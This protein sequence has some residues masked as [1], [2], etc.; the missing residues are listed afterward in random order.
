MGDGLRVSVGGAGGRNR[1]AEWGSVCG[2]EGVGEVRSGFEK[3][4]SLE[5]VCD[6]SMVFLGCEVISLYCCF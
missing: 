3:E 6:A 4:R 1:V 5:G 2:F